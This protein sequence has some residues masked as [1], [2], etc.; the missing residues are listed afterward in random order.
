M[1]PNRLL[2]ASRAEDGKLS[3]QDILD[4]K[5]DMC[6]RDFALAQG[7]GSIPVK[8]E[9]AA[10]GSTFEISGAGITEVNLIYSFLGGVDNGYILYSDVERLF[11]AQLPANKTKFSLTSDLLGIAS[12]N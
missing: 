2:L 3:Y 6:L 10:D 5:K 12:S 11:H 9:I 8:N 7:D 1:S 4:T